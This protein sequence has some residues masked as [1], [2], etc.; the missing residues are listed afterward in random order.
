M[1]GGGRGGGLITFLNTDDGF[2]DVRRGGGEGEKICTSLSSTQMY[3]HPKN[4]GWSWSVLRAHTS[5]FSSKVAVLVRI[6]Y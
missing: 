5:F 4:K 1:E 6:I 2:N 3:D